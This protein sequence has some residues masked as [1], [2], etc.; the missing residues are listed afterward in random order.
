MNKSNSEDI[1]LEKIKSL[2]KEYV[3]CKIPFFAKIC[4]NS[5]DSI[6]IEYNDLVNY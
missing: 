1:Y 6:C 5:I 3:T 2:Y 4:R